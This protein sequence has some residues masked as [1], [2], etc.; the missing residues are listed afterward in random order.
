MEVPA[1]CPLG[2]ADAALAPTWRAAW[3]DRTAALMAAFAEY[4]YRDAAALPALLAPAG[5]TLAAAL[6]AGDVVAFL[7]VCPGELAV[8]AFRGTADVGDWAIDLNA[9]P[10]PMPGRPGIRIHSGFWDAYARVAAEIAAAVGQLPANGFGEVGL[11]ITGH[12]LGG[13]LAQI[14]A[15]AL[16]RDTLAAC[17]TFGSPRVASAGFDALVKC[18][19]YR[20]VDDWDLVP[21][22]PPPSPAWLGGY[23]HTGD[24]RL[25]AG[26]HPAEAQRRDRDLVPRLL[27]DLWSLAVWPLTGRLTSVDD[28]MI[29][30]YR[31]KLAAIAAGHASAGA[32][33]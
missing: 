9:V 12:S 22:V 18:P 25:L 28:H 7:A 21:A 23:R 15:A 6:A 1:P 4:A 24:A 5:F 32:K 31:A 3:S 27:A 29:W 19:H 14:A 10:R 17:Y 11:Y 8:L 26:P 33:P 2:P 16:E 13:A 20:V 30:T